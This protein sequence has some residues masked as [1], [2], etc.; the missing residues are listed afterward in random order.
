[1]D[2]QEYGREGRPHQS[3][4]NIAVA[5]LQEFQRL[6]E[7]SQAT[8]IESEEVLR[9][10]ARSVKAAGPICCGAAWPES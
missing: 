8:A 7:N 5:D 3:L 4:M 2:G 6:R 9:E 1:M 10:I